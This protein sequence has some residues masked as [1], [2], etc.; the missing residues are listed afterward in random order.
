MISEVKLE[1]ILRCG[2][3]MAKEVM[4]QAPSRQAAS[5]TQTPRAQQAPDQTQNIFLGT[6]CFNFQS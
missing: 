5:P 4:V 6:W 1:F 2:S 3:K